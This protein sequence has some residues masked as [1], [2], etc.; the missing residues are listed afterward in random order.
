MILKAIAVLGI[1]AGLMLFFGIGFVLVATFT[2]K[3][4][5]ESEHDDGRE[6]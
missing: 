4:L 6:E 3:H 2:F 5:K 1:V